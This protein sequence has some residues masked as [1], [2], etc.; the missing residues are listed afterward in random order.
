M[1]KNDFDFIVEK[2]ENAKMAISPNST[3]TVRMPK[4]DLYSILKLMYFM[5]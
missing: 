1:I 3:K 5:S 2:T 4:L